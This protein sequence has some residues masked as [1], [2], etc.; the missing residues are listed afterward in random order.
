MELTDPL[1]ALP[2][3]VLQMLGPL[4]PFL[5]AARGM[6]PRHTPRLRLP[7]G[8]LRLAREEVG[9]DAGAG[10]SALDDGGKQVHEVE[11]DGGQ[12][13]LVVLRSLQWTRD[14]GVQ[15]HD[16]AVAG[17]G[18]REGGRE[19]GCAHSHGGGCRENLLQ[20]HFCR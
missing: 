12:R 18:G 2:R 14:H 17:V 19:G 16:E 11:F 7:V 15:S 13:R 8:G 20:D 5:R 9:D 6:E 10:V 1:L 4:G 3:V